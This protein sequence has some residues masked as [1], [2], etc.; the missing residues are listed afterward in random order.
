MGKDTVING[1]S[2]LG[3]IT[4]GNI[5]EVGLGEIDFPDVGSGN[6]YD[7]KKRHRQDSL[8]NDKRRSYDDR[9]YGSRANDDHGYSYNHNSRGPYSDDNKRRRY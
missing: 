8:D 3:G 7:E 2:L 9:N 5:E 1:V 4:Y 6:D